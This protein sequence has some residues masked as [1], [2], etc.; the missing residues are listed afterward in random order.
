MR[1]SSKERSILIRRAGDL[2]VT[3]QSMYIYD[4]I[5]VEYEDFSPIFALRNIR[6]QDV[7]N[8]MRVLLNSEVDLPES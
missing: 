8:A 3:Q 7:P 6:V 4:L 1:D 5:V 2:T